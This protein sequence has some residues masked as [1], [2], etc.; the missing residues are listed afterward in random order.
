MPPST[1]DH[2]GIKSGIFSITRPVYSGIGVSDFRGSRIAVLFYVHAGENQY[3]G[4]ANF[5]KTINSRLVV[6][7][8]ISDPGLCFL[9]K[10]VAVAEFRGARRTDLGAR[11]LLPRNHTVRTHNAFAHAWIQRTPFVLGL[12]ERAGHHAIAAADALPYVVDDRT[13]FGFVECS[14]RTDRRA[15][16]SLAVH[17]QSAHELVV[18]GHD[19]RV[20]MFRLHR[21]GRYPIVVGQLILLCACGFTLLAADAHGRVIQQRLTHGNFSLALRNGPS[22]R[23]N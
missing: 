5:V 1:S 21:L 10:V 4:P 15:G 12:R 16:W 17:A 18:L 3:T 6:R 22:F 23:R 19:D 20:L 13:L 14:H 8:V 9:N 2:T 11:R 7:R